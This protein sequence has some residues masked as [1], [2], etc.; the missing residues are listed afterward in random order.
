MVIKMKIAVIGGGNIGTLMAAEFSAKGFETSIYSSR[1][2]GKK[3]V[4]VYDNDDN[5]LFTSNELLITNDI[6]LAIND[7]KVV[8]VTYPPEL[9]DK[10]SHELDGKLSNGTCLGI[11]PGSGGAEF[12]FNNLIKQGVTL[13]GLQ[14]VHSIARIKEIGKSVYMLG[15]KESISI[16]VFK[17]EN[18]EF[19]K[20]FLQDS[21]DMPCHVLDNYLTITLSPSNQILHTTRLCMLFNDYRFGDSYPENILFYKTW[22]D[23][24]SDLMIKCDEELQILCDK[25]SFDL[26]DVKS[27]K[28]HYESHSVE[29]MTEKI[30]NIPA[31]QELTSP[32]LENDENEWVP[33]FN[34]RYFSSDFPFGL[35][36]ILDIAN[37]Y[38]TPTEHLSYVWN[39]FFE[40]AKPKVCFNL[41]KYGIESIDEF[42]NY[43]K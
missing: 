22:D 15:R 10:L 12:A 26:K 34:S 5:Y 40:L 24:S 29:A 42:E 38:G 2:N 18:V 19:I 13:F 31:F 14:R 17:N 25:I 6:D 36:I 4:E 28:D 27:L 23:K 43:Y 11:V 9:F 32:M 30:S 1:N 7:A 39:W 20:E 3:R 16:S 8:F 37:L 35:K 41:E 33:D 21:L